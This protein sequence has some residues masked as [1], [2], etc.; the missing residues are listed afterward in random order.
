MKLCGVLFWVIYTLLLIYVA[1]AGGPARAGVKARKGCATD[2]DQSGGNAGAG[3]DDTAAH[4]PPMGGPHTRSGGEGLADNADKTQGSSSA[5]DTMPEPPPTVLWVPMAAAAPG[6]YI[7]SAPA[8]YGSGNKRRLVPRAGA[9]DVDN[10]NWWKDY[11]SSTRRP[12]GW[13]ES[14][15]SDLQS[16]LAVGQ[17]PRSHEY[18]MLWRTCEVA[19][20]M[21]SF[22]TQA[23]LRRVALL[24]PVRE[25][26]CK[27][28]KLWDKVSIHS[29][30]SK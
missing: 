22:T 24:A 28:T 30:L 16:V 12:H 29:S 6:T 25:Y 2:H 3:G 23:R 15:Q 19:N 8:P 20:K 18:I 13:M 9:G 26:M 4:G 1:L 11:F 14:M 7:W 27:R 21:E 10:L 17:V 5:Q